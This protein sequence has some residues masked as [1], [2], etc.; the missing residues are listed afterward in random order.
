MKFVSL[1]DSNPNRKCAKY[2]EIKKKMSSV[3]KS[4]QPSLS[5]SVRTD[6][7]IYMAK[8]RSV[9]FFTTVISNAPKRGVKIKFHPRTGLEGPEEE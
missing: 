4:V 3:V 2:S 5:S 1:Y 9:F 7:H 8:L 6:K